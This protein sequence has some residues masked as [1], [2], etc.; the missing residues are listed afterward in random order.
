MVLQF[1]A[2]ILQVLVIE[3]VL[4]ISAG[5][6][7]RRGMPLEVDHVGRLAVGP[8]AEEVVVAHF[9][10]GGGRGVARDMS[11]QFGVAA[12]SLH[13]HRHG[14]PA[15]DRADAVGSFLGN[16]PVAFDIALAGMAGSTLSKTLGNPSGG[17]PFSVFIDK[18]ERIVLQKVGKLED[19]DFAAM[20]RILKA[21]YAVSPTRRLG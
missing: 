11:A 3:T 10:E 21:L 8:A 4:Q 15:V 19:S 17:L 18:D 2:E 5:I 9:V 12:I 16:W 13:H 7:A 6:V 14:V 1:L 20:T